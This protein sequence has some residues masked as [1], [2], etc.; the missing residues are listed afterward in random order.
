MK[1][2]KV[3]DTLT[4]PL[5]VV[6]L[7]QAILAKKG[8]GKSYTAAVQAEEM[9]KRG[10]QVVIIDPTGVWWGL[11]SSADGTRAG[12]RIAILGGEHCDVA[13][14]EHAGEIVAGA[15]SD[16]RF[17][18]ILDLSLF[19]KGPMQRFM[20]A[21]LEKLYHANRNAMHLIVDEA[22][23]FAPQKPFGEEARCLGAMQDVVRRGR[24]RGIGITLITQRP[25]VL[26]K[27]VLSQA[28]TLCA[29]RMLHPREL[30][31]V[32]EWVDVHGD[33]KQAKAMIE[34]LP[35]LPIGEAWFWAPGMDIF[36][37][38]KIR[39]RETFDSSATP[40]PG[41][42][43][44]QPKVLAPIDIQNLG[45]QIAA[46]A[47]EQKSNAPGELKKKIRELQA[48][49][50][51]KHPEPDRA[52]L[53]KAQHDAV[54]NII[55]PQI[56]K[57]LTGPLKEALGQIEMTRA[58]VLKTIGLCEPLVDDLTRDCIVQAAPAPATAPVLA[59]RTSEASIRRA[60]AIPGETGVLSGTARKIACVAA[61]YGRD[62]KRIRRDLLASMLGMTDGGSF[63]GRLSEARTA[64]AI[65][66]DGGWI[67]A[68]EAGQ[69]EYANGFRV[70]TT[71]E[72][73]LAICEELDS[74]ILYT[75]SPWTER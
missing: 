67:E 13:L 63:S 50:A 53:L 7:T 38:A 72:E 23:L 34:S 64:G 48:E 69:R 62:G 1:G 65:I 42:E 45:A 30:G 73:V 16:R 12:F 44:A 17:S 27:D 57:S 41:E 9:L 21:F 39:R 43:M 68:T 59:A 14:E 31:A 32:E 71:T 61:A 3:S 29:L 52:A 36:E 15:I 40:K 70:P 8:S 35:S 46:T 54:R 56:L 24:A 75:L 28:D 60:K 25:Q 74:E 22:D 37:R 6:T 2:L 51:A 47:E 33:P 26:N 19:R 18:A 4:L 49:L 20:A 11:K 66:S 5:E 58:T 10:Q 55:L